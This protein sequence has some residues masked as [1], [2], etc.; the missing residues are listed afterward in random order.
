MCH[1]VL[2]NQ[3]LKVLD[4]AK[5]KILG[6][7]WETDSSI[8]RIGWNVCIKLQIWLEVIWSYLEF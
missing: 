7:T 5:G 3:I 1:I 4:M 6:I 8:L 2:V